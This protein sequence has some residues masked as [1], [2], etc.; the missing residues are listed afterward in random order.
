M[1]HVVA[2]CKQVKEYLS[3]ESMNAVVGVIVGKE[4][5]L[6]RAIFFY[7]TRCI[8]GNRLSTYVVQVAGGICGCLK[9]DDYYMLH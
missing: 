8:L 5:M 7:I 6:D 4:L 2:F 9:P 3:L 1:N